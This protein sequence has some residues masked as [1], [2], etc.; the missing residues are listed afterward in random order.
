MKLAVLITILV[1]ALQFSVYYILLPFILMK[2]LA[3]F[4]VTAGFWMCVLIMWGI[5][6]LIGLM[7]Q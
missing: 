4:G 7:K 3:L 2:V 5:Y 1:L 6:I